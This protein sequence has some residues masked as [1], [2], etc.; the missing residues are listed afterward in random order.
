LR[1]AT[2]ERYTTGKGGSGG[3]RQTRKKPTGASA[4]HLNAAGGEAAL[5]TL[6]NDLL[7]VCPAFRNEI[8][9]DADWTCAHPHNNE[10]ANLLISLR[11]SLSHDKQMRVCSRAKMILEGSVPSRD[12][13]IMGSKGQSMHRQVLQI[14]QAQSSVHFPFEFIDYGSLY[15]RNNFYQQDHQNFFGVDETNGPLAISL[16]REKVPEDFSVL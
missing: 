9:G 10:G 6:Q 16:K 13:A 5:E 11:R 14:Q 8:G 7:A 3:D 2:L 15:Y 1:S 4:A 12:P